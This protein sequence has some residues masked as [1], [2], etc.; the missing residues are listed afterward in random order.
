M[1]YAPGISQQSPAL[2]L[3]KGN[4][5]GTRGKGH[6][7]IRNAQGVRS[8]T[9]TIGKRQSHASDFLFYSL[10]DF[11][12]QI[13]KIDLKLDSIG[14]EAFLKLI[15]G[16]IQQKETENNLLYLGL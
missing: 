5:T 1:R 14:R 16:C 11:G 10:D 6:Q 2:N 9:D 15:I 7:K 8:D 12:D 4:Y 3:F 13:L